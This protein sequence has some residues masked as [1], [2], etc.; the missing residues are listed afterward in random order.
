MRARIIWSEKVFWGMWRQHRSA[1]Q[2]S[3]I[4]LQLSDYSSNHLR[5]TVRKHTFWH[6]YPKNATACASTQSDQSLLSALRN[7]A[8]LAIKNVWSDWANV[9]VN[10]SICWTTYFLTS[11]FSAMMWICRWSWISSVFL[12]P[13]SPLFS[14]IKWWNHKGHNSFWINEFIFVLVF[15]SSEI[16]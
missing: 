10:L 5:C 12:T 2:C 7:F 11:Q 8:S 3:L 14:I 15:K 6:V 16:H 1:N 13:W 4:R 9:Q